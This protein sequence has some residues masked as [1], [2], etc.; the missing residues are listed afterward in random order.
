[1]CCGFGQVLNQSTSLDGL[2]KSKGYA[3]SLLNH[4]HAVYGPKDSASFKAA[5]RRFA[6]SLAG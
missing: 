1:S 5:Q 2:K 3:G 6:C 4:F